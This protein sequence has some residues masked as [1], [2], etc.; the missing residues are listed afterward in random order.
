MEE[1]ERLR[2][3]HDDAATVVRALTEIRFRLL[4]FV[5]TIAG[6]AVALL[7]RTDDPAGLLAAGALGLVATFGIYLYEL[8]NSQLHAAARRRALRAAEALGLAPVDEPEPV[9]LFG[10]IPAW[11]R[12]GLGLVYGAALAAWAYLVA[13]G[14]LA[15]AEVP[16]PRGLG[17]AAGIAFGAATALWVE[18]P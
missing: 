16:E 12:V 13:W 8:R 2:L 10:R 15:L 17:A 1:Q 11:H 14:A 7:S 4:A 5:P 3:E 18:R 9:R 6:A